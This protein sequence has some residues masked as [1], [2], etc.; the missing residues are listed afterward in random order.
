MA[1]AILAGRLVTCEG[2]GLGAI[3][4]AA[5]VLE[6]DR[7]AWIGAARDRDTNVPV[8]LDASHELITPGLVDAHTHAAFMGSR[9][10]EYA[11][12]MAGGD[13]EAIAK[14]GGGI[15]A[16][17]RAVAAASEDDL[18]LELVTRL[19]RMASLGVTTCEVKSGYGLSGEHE[20]KQL[21][22][23]ARAASRTDVPRVVA[24]YLALHALPPG[25][26]RDSFVAAV[27]D[28]ILPSVASE[29]LARFV[30]A[31]VDRSAFRVHEARRVGVRARALGLGVR[32]H[33]GQF[34]D[35]GGAELAAEL[36]ARERGQL[37]R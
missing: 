31:Y 19:R 25:V 29:G 28:E 12:R 10:D 9:H 11:V 37:Q 27:A 35:V 15:L 1:G 22:A 30:D 8:V 33:V 5:L 14:A 17:Q 36:G 6:G 32:M 16:T 13:Y 24:T 4:D 34:A 26:D 7:V 23:I 3:D 2:D 18:A 20:R 21:R